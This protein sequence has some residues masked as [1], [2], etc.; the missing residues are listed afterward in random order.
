MAWQLHFA[1]LVL[2]VPSPDDADAD[3]SDLYSLTNFRPTSSSRL[4]LRKFKRWPTEVQK[5]NSNENDK[6][7]HCDNNANML[8]RSVK[9]ADS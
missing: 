3:A 5:E 7:R 9:K 6:D 1:V 4:S 2:T 8:L